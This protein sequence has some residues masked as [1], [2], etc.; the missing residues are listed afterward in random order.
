MFG[1]Q[2]VDD[3]LQFIGFFDYGFTQDIQ[4]PAGTLEQTVYLMSIGPGIRYNI[5]RFV[6]VRFDWGFQLHQ[7][8][9]GSVTGSRA[10]L[11]VTVAY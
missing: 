6:T 7:A 2:S 1:D 8:P 9:I 3:S 5:D 4:S 10:E 11:S